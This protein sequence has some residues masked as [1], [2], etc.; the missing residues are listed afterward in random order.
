MA[1]VTDA[2]GNVSS[3]ELDRTWHIVLPVRVPAR[4]QTWFVIR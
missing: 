2:F 1:T 4:S 3:Y